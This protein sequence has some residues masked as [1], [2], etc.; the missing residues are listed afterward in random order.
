MCV[1]RSAFTSV[2]VEGHGMVRGICIHDLRSVT[3]FTSV[4]M[5]YLLFTIYDLGSPFTSVGGV[6]V[7][8]DL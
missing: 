5:G 2:V 1:L 3:A 7:I 6:S 8:Y 4:R